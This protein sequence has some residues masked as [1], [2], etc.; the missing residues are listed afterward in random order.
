MYFKLCTE[1]FIIIGFENLHGPNLAETLEIVQPDEFD[2]LVIGLDLD[3][4]L[5]SSDADHNCVRLSGLRATRRLQVRL[6]I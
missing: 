3:Q 6:I 4:T 1:Y 2:A 5:T